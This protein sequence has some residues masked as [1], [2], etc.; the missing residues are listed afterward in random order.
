MTKHYNLFL[1]RIYFTKN[2][3]TQNTFVYQPTLDALELK[4]DKGIENTVRWK[5]KGVYNSKI[6]PLHSA[7]LHSS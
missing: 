4:K 3:G 5:S 1:G 6:K 7:F 2:D